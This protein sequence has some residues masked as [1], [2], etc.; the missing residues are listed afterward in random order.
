MQGQRETTNASDAQP[1]LPRLLTVRD[2]CRELQLSRPLVYDLIN[3]GHIRSIV[4]TVGSDGRKMRRIPP[5]ALE[6]FIASRLSD[7]EPA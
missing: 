6:A 2:V 4:V 1:P 5:E 3:R 7:D